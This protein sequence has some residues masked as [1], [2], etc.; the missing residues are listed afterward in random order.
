[1]D[2]IIL[3]DLEDVHEAFIMCKSGIE[4][5]AIGEDGE[6]EEVEKF[7]PVG[8]VETPNGVPKNA[9]GADG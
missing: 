9:K 3:G 5:E 2:C 1:M 4:G 7:V 6:D 8:I